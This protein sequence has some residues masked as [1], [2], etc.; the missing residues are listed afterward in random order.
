M[1]LRKP[2]TRYGTKSVTVSAERGVSAHSRDSDFS[3]CQRTGEFFS[4]SGFGI[5]E[6]DIIDQGQAILIGLYRDDVLGS[7]RHG[8]V[9][10]FGITEI[11]ADPGLSGVGQRLHI[12]AVQTE[13]NVR[14]VRLQSFQI[15]KRVE[16]GTAEREGRVAFGFALFIDDGDDG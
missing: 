10:D 13:L 5:G 7:G 9:I 4:E 12:G 6:D 14:A 1:S 15:V 16:V 2:G 8:F 3:G 11:N